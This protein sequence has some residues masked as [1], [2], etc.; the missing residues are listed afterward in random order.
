MGDQNSVDVAQE[1]HERVLIKGG[2]LKEEETLRFD[3]PFPLGDVLE[4]STWAI[5]W[6]LGWWIETKVA[7][8]AAGI[9]SV[10][11]EASRRA[12]AAA[13]LPVAHEKSF[14]YMTHFVAWGTEVD[15]VRGTVGVPL[16]RRLQLFHLVP[17]SDHIVRFP[18]LVVRF[19]LFAIRFPMIAV[20]FP[21]V[22]RRFLADPER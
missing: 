12:Y 18:M 8:P 21:L 19:L 9:D 2:C 6:S 16:S 10:R 11:L 5:T 22:L 4:G 17:F 15:S 7:D 3:G 1:T 13:G 20:R 14:E